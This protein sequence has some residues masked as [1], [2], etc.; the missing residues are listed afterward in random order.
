[1]RA[2]EGMKNR[3]LSVVTGMTLGAFVGTLSVTPIDHVVGWYVPSG[4]AAI[5]SLAGALAG[6]LIAS[7]RLFQQAGVL[8][9]AAYG[10]L[11]GTLVARVA[12]W[13][14]NAQGWALLLITFGVTCLVCV[15]GALVTLPSAPTW[16]AATILLL[17]TSLALRLWVESKPGTLSVAV[18]IAMPGVAHIALRKRRATVTVVVVATTFLS[19][20]LGYLVVMPFLVDRL[21]RNVPLFA[22]ILSFAALLGLSLGLLLVRRDSRHAVRETV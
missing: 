5:A 19:V 12:S 4:R 13:Q 22:I 17:L 1:M 15:L 10:I 11:A 7:Q 20:L 18:A 21:L 16:M 3:A 2:G 8:A 14:W 6:G 9:V